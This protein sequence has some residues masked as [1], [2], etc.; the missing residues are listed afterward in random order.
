[1]ASTMINPPFNDRRKHPERPE[2]GVS[3]ANSVEPEPLNSVTERTRRQNG[4]EFRPT[5]DRKP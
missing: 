1:M 4:G 3:H 2:T 5:T